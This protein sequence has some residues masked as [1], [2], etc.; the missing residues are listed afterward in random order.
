M[1]VN[2]KKEKHNV[3]I[4]WMELSSG[5]FRIAKD[6]KLVIAIVPTTSASACAHFLMGERKTN[7]D[8]D[9]MKKIEV[10]MHPVMKIA[11]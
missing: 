5:L 6:I 7:W 2:V 10:T 3:K 4:Q 9:I 11:S 8:R 1:V